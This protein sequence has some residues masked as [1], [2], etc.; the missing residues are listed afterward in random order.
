MLRL[1][2]TALTL[3]QVF[4]H[5]TTPNLK[6]NHTLQHTDSVLQDRVEVWLPWFMY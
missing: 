2:L 1:T 3:C 5:F 4:M 6:L